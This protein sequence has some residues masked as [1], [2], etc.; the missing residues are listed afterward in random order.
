MLLAMAI[1]D[2]IKI[3][4]IWSNCSFDPSSDLMAEVDPIMG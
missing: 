2:S 1:W 3:L 4:L